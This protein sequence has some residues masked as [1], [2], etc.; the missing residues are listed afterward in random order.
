[1]AMTPEG[2]AK[3]PARRGTRKQLG[4]VELEWTCPR[5]QARNPGAVKSCA[6][7][8]APQPA[9]VKFETPAQAEVVERGSEEAEAIASAV[10]AGADIYCPF[11]GTRNKADATACVQCHAPLTDGKAREAGENLGAINTAPLPDILCNVCGAKN[12]GAAKICKQCGS[13]LRRRDD[14]QT[15]GAP[16]P[17]PKPEGGGVA[18]WW[19][20]GGALLLIA[21]IGLFAWFGSRTESHRAVA[22][23][24]RW[25]R[26]ITVAGLVPVTRTAWQ[27]QLPAGADVDS[28]QSVLR[29]TSDEPVAG[30]REVC[31]APYAVDTGTGYGE[32]VQDCEYQVYDQQCRY[33]TLQWMPIDTLQSS[34]VGFTPQWPTVGITP[35]RRIADQREEYL[36]TVDVRGERYSFSLPPDQYSLCQVGS[37][38]NIAVNAFGSLV[39]AEPQ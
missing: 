36:C 12:A 30:S 16:A 37:N 39:K 29:Y 5:C 6:T 26:T 18:L 20:V 11:C 7:C 19:F 25:V 10:A 32:V 21:V 35:D 13:P 17:L 14:K 4:Y 28:C 9:D 27:D 33:Q 24:A 38:W 23:E 3:P 8:G 22:Q 34:G 2:G 1:M 15:P 31:G